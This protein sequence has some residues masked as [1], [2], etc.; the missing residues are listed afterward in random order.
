MVYNW[1]LDV[2]LPTHSGSKYALIHGERWPLCAAEALSL[3]KGYRRV[4]RVSE[5]YSENIYL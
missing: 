2:I 1:T 4:G 5:K 3:Q